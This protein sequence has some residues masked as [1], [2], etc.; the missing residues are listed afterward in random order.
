MTIE[1]LNNG[2]SLLEQRTKINANFAA[3][4]E[5]AAA[6]LAAAGVA[7]T[8]AAAKYTKPSTGIPATDMASS[9]QANLTKASTA[10]QPADV[11]AALAAHVAAAD[12]HTAYMTVTE[13]Q[14][15]FALAEQG[16]KADTAL[17]PGALPDGTTVTAAQI[18]DAT[19]AGRNLLKAANSTDQRT[20]LG[21]SAVDNTADT[22]KPVSTAQAAAI[23]AAVSAHE[24]AADP[25]PTYMTQAESDARYATAAQGAKADAALR[26]IPI[27]AGALAS[28]TGTAGLVY[29][30]SDGADVGAKLTW[31][32]PLGAGSPTWCWW[33]WPQAAY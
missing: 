17:Q 26:V 7:Q 23:A 25:H 11:A 13:G 8:S 9:V 31:A 1:T 24:A 22:N 19:A 12:P 20:Y 18:S 21:L 4:D 33:L 3:V 5:A 15:I 28:T 2:A 16:Q 10:S 14:A 6:A 32:T 27:A 30:L 29:E